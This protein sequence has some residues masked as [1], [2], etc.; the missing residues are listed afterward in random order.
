M[1]GNLLISDEEWLFREVEL[2]RLHAE[3]RDTHL[4]YQSWFMLAQS[5]LLAALINLLLPRG[6]DTRKSLLY[7]VCGVALALGLCSWI[8]QLRHMLDSDARIRRIREVS[9]ALRRPVITTSGSTV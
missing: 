3:I 7:L 6:L 4:K 5:V 8:L 2:H 9:V 1:S